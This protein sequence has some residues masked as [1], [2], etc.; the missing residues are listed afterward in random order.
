M[1]PV[2]I[3]GAARSGSR[4]YLSLFNQ[5]TDICMIEE[6][7]I[8]NPWWLHPDFSRS[9]KSHVGDLTKDQNIDK[10]I[11]LIFSKKLYGYYWESI[12]VGKES[13]KKRILESE[14]SIKG[15]F[16]AV[17][18]ESCAHEN[19]GVP[20][21]KYPLH[22]SYVPTLLEW[23]PDCKIIHIM[24]DPR[25][26]FSSQI[27]KYAREDNFLSKSKQLAL[28]LPMLSH[29]IIQF[30]W[31]VNVYETHKNLPNYFLSKYEDI[32]QRPETQLKDMCQFLGIP[33]HEK[34]LDIMVVDSSY[35]GAHKGI[36]EKSLYKW[37]ERISP[38]TASLISKITKKHMKLVGYC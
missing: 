28:Y 26:F 7:H 24:R 18:L 2:F 16:E 12:S 5:H 32:V 30:M 34:M 25:A 37:K 14:R 8:I 11:D 3:I 21:A 13:L 17:M 33:F 1:E 6:P 35:G 22:L 15:V 31:S 23:F 10:L 20:G 9:I 27:Y 29:V 19:K 36:S 4:I 38:V